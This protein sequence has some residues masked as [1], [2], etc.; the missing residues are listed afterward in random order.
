VSEGRVITKLS[1]TTPKTGPT[2]DLIYGIAGGNVGDALRIDPH[3][4][5][6]NKIGHFNF[7]YLN[8]NK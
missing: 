1:A 8:N 7:I 6:V 2:S 5:E 4:G 3:T